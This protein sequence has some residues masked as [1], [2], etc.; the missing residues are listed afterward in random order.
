M[1]S[2]NVS[3]KI[4]RK[5]SVYIAAVLPTFYVCVYDYAFAASEDWALFPV[6]FT[7]SLNAGIKLDTQNGRPEDGDQEIFLLSFLSSPPRS[8]SLRLLFL[9][10]CLK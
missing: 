7:Q 8:G 10:L 9:R 5:V 2:L 6:F 4:R 1:Y 3:I